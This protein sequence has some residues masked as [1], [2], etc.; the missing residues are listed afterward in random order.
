[1]R[2]RNAIGVFIAIAGVALFSVP[3]ASAKEYYRGCLVGTH[4]NYVL[5]TDD[6]QLFRLHSHS[7]EDFK[8]HLG[9][10][11]EIKG[12]LSDHDRER[13][14]QEQAPNERAAGVEMPR[15]GLNV[16]HIKTVSHG[17]AEVKNG[18]AVLIVPVPERRGDA[19][20]QSGA[21]DRDRDHDRDNDQPELQHFTGCLV[22]TEDFFVL[23]ATDGT[24]Y[25]LRST[26]NLRE[27]VGETIDVAGRIDNTRR[28]VEAQHQAELAQQLGVQL[29]QMAVNVSAVRTLAKGCATEPR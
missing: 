3:S 7:E 18:V 19:L 26:D 27:H 16:S 28:E 12:Q 10:V 2:M 29:P 17:C 4:D 8:H 22:G 11:V 5:R 15:H 25:R 9:D 6:G 14:A 21:I 13:E 24:L 20:P 1:M 23:K